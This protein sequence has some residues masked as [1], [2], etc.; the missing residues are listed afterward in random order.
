[1][2]AAPVADRPPVPAA[3]RNGRWLVGVWLAALGL[4]ALLLAWRAWSIGFLADD[5]GLIRRHAHPLFVLLTTDWCD[6][7]P[8]GYYRPIVRWTLDADFSMAGFSP[9]WYHVTNTAVHAANAVLVA[10]LYRRLDLSEGVT[11][12]LLA[13]SLFAVLPIHTDNVYWIAAR[14]DSICTF[15]YLATLI[16]FAGFLARSR[17]SDATLAA[18]CSLLALLAKEMAWS[19]P[20]ATLSLIATSDRCSA[21]RRPAMRLWLWMAVLYG[22]YFALRYHAVGELIGH[23]LNNAD[24]SVHRIGESLLVTPMIFAAAGWGGPQILKHFTSAFYLACLALAALAV[25]RAGSARRFCRLLAL[26]TVSLVPVVGLVNRWYL[27]LPSAFACMGVAYLWST[28]RVRP[29]WARATGIFFAISTVVFAGVLVYESV[30]WQRAARISDQTLAE[31]KQ[32]L[33]SADRLL[34][35]NLPCAWQPRET[36]GAKAIFSCWF[37]QAVADV[38]GPAHAAPDVVSYLCWW[39]PGPVSQISEEAPG[40]YRV[41]CQDAGWFSFHLAP[42]VGVANRLPAV[43]TT[44]WG[45]IAIENERSLSFTVREGAI[46]AILFFDGQRW[47][48]LPTAVARSTSARHRGP[49]SDAAANGEGMGS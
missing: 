14:T 46:D 49:S 43:V 29:A 34:V 17:T 41:A 13:G 25:S 16:F 33:A 19:L 12:A 30:V 3:R 35:V 20:G 39:S 42:F 28:S 44:G 40:R 1:M 8:T 10:L 45:E 4:F 31:V 36:I 47:Q 5:W 11:P 9:G 2:S 6:L 48:R 27:Y 21:T 38:V 7:W 24:L 26:F 18:V 22:V 15:F 32:A 37:A 23:R